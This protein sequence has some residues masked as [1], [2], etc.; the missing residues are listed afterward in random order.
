MLGNQFLGLT[1]LKQTTTIDKEFGLQKDCNGMPL[2]TFW[3]HSIYTATSV[4][5]F[6]HTHKKGKSMES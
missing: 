6:P 5:H 3:N 4:F 2:P 1:G